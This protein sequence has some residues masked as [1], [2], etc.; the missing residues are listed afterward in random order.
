[1]PK[2]TEHAS[3][4]ASKL[5]FIGDSGSGKTGAL[6]SLVKAGYELR[7]LDFDSGLDILVNLLRA[8][9]NASELLARVEYETLTDKFKSRP[10]GGVILDGI[11][12]AYSS[13]LKLLTN[14]NT[15]SANFGNI[16]TWDENVVLVIDSLTFMCMAAFR[17]VDAVYHFKDPRQTYGEAQT[18]IEDVLGMLYSDRIKCNVIVNS[19]ITFIDVDGGFTKGYPS[20]IGKALSPRIPRFFNSVIEAKTKG[21]G[22]SAKHV[23]LTVPDGMIELK[24]PAAP[25]KIP[26]ELPIETGLATYLNLIQGEN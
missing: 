1:M 24:N 7:I 11:P 18:Q 4:S 2:L 15:P 14:W 13:A 26:A 9:P 3:S 25:G 12:K 10:N 6:A 5:L 19:H 21:T 16:E 22:A 20:S 8:E 23:I 17:W